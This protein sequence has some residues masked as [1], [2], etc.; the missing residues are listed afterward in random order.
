MSSVE[1]RKPIREVYLTFELKEEYRLQD[2]HH[3]N[4][5]ILDIYDFKIFKD[6]TEEEIGKVSLL[7]ERAIQW[8]DLDIQIGLEGLLLSIQ[9]RENWL[10]NLK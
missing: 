2:C 1:C 3:Y 5:Y 6:K 9:L 4:F 8:K 7:G 10:N